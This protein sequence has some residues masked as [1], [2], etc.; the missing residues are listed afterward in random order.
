V[1]NFIDVKLALDDFHWQ[2]VEQNV[3]CE[4]R[5]AASTG[6]DPSGTE[7]FEDVFTHLHENLVGFEHYSCQILH[8]KRL[9]RGEL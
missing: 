1:G 5:I 3:S 9:R 8:G 7:A 4:L 2:E 6:S